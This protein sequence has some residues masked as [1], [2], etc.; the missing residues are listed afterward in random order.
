[1]SKRLLSLICVL[2]TH[3]ICANAAESNSILVQGFVKEASGAPI[4]NIAVG[5]SDNPAYLSA[6]TDETGAY[7]IEVSPARWRIAPDAR[8]L[9][10][11]GY[12][13]LREFATNL[14]TGPR[15]FNFTIQRPQSVVSGKVIDDTG[16]PISNF[17]IVAANS[18]NWFYA[19]SS[20]SGDFSLKLSNDTWFIG[21]EGTLENT[22]QR[23]LYWMTYQIPVPNANIITNLT[24]PRYASRI[25]GVLR[26]PGGAPIPF[27]SI[28]LRTEINGSSLWIQP[29]T[30][31]NG[32]FKAEVPNATWRLQPSSYQLNRLGYYFD[33]STNVSVLNETNSAVVLNVAVP[34]KS[35]QGTIR[36]EN[37][38]GV[39]NLVV[40]T[41][42][43]NTGE[44]YGSSDADG[45]YSIPVFPGNWSLSFDTA[46][47]RAEK[48]FALPAGSI[49]VSA[50]TLSVTQDLSVIKAPYTIKVTAVDENGVS[51]PLS[52]ASISTVRNGQNL[53]NYVT[54]FGIS[55]EAEF[56]VFPGTWQVGVGVSSAY[57]SPAGQTIVISNAS[58]ELQFVVPSWKFD[59]TITGRVVGPDGAALSN[60]FL[61]LQGLRDV[62]D[63]PV[64]ATGH[65][66]FP[67]YSGQWTIR[68]A[69][70]NYLF[71]NTFVTAPEG[72]STNR[73]IHARRVESP[74]QVTLHSA[75]GSSIT[76]FAVYA[77]R[78]DSDQN[79]SVGSNADENPTTLALFPGEWTLSI[80]YV[81]DTFRPVPERQIM[82]PAGG[83]NLTIELESSAPT[84]QI[85]GKIVSSSGNPLADAIV[86][87]RTERFRT[88]PSSTNTTS[89]IDGTFQLGAFAGNWDFQARTTNGNI[90]ANKILHIMD[91][92]DQNLG[93]ITLPEA[94]QK[95]RLRLVTTNGVPIPGPFYFQATATRF[96]GSTRYWS[97]DGGSENSRTLDV[98][99]GQWEIAIIADGIALIGYKNPAPQLVT[100]TDHDLDV[101]VQVESLADE[102][103]PPRFTSAST[104]GAFGSARLTYETTA[105]FEIQTSTDLTNW[106]RHED[107][108]VNGSFYDFYFNKSQTNRAQYFRALR[109]N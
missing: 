6:L 48:Y 41:G 13:A 61:R 29:A 69:D 34:P 36:D 10:D 56:T 28:E 96:V 73:I 19:T 54:P 72:S 2:I 47:L 98:S 45:R 1:M 18:P 9:N 88:S 53:Q 65:F 35:I 68:S 23:G 63:Q 97:Y 31:S 100:I 78:R 103:S 91:G 49:T 67:I 83:T 46:S 86:A 7:S 109:L 39:S 94:T 52:T 60:I 11:R 3:L 92:Q 90:T 79:Y 22:Y 5:F 33:G 4:T 16:A 12:L 87:V 21:A 101:D 26:A 95:I 82:I 42:G 75:D 24:I 102:S 70:T 64:D 84:A 80:P 99:P 57:R 74:L 77:R 32:V 14:T 30:D 104:I 17:K 106:T 20:V 15:T 76:M 55:A 105:N 93:T 107:I 58:K 40:R 38:A 62:E 108:H 50:D 85:R 66:N 44:F 27:V 37:G 25:E 59:S 71:E 8:A 89:G 81:D 43:F 51:V